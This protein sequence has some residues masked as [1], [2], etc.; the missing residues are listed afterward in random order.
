MNFSPNQEDSPLA[1]IVEDDRFMRM[2]LTTVMEQD[3]YQVVEASNGEE[4][5]TAYTRYQ[6]DVVLLDAIMPIMDGFT[7]CR[8]LQ[9]LPRGASTPILMITSLN[10]ET[11][12]DLAFDVGATDFITKPIHWA[13]LRQRVRRMLQASRATEKLQRNFLRERLITGISQH[14]RRSLNLKDI[15]DTTVVDV[16]QFLGCDQV[17]VYRFYPDGS[18]TVVSEQGILSNHKMLGQYI[19]DPCLPEPYP[20][21]FYQGWF[22]EIADLEQANLKPD[23]LQLL[24][25]LGIKARLVVPILKGEILW[26]LLIAHHYSSSREWFAEEIELLQQLADQLSLALAQAELLETIQ[27]REER[28]RQLA[29]NIDDVFWISDP[30]KNKIIYISPAYEKIWGFSCESIYRNAKSFLDAIPDEDRERVIA[31]LPKQ[32]LGNYDEE[33]RVVQPDGTIRWIRDRAFPISDATGQ[34]YRIVGIAADITQRKQAEANIYQALQQEKEFSELKSRFISIAS[35]EFRTPLT[36]ILAAAES[37]EYYGHK[38]TEEKKTSYLQRIKQSVKYMT[39]MLNDVL[40]LAKTEAGKTASNPTWIDLGEF[41]Y[42]LTQEIQISD[43]KQHIITF[44]SCANSNGD[45]PEKLPALTDEKSLR[46]IFSNL[47]SNAIKYSPL[48][49]VI[50]FK[51][52]VSDEVAVFQIQDQGIGVPVEDQQRLF[53]SF[54]RCTNVGNIPGTGL[55]LAIVKKSVDLLGGSITIDSEVGV[56]TTFTVMLPLNTYKNLPTEKSLLNEQ[57]ISS[58]KAETLRAL[59]GGMNTQG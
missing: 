38:W 46:H 2:Q 22:D 48:G 18:G 31:A 16:Q 20:Q 13:V 12:V 25:K 56:G 53:E 45:T 41:C 54:H 51:L 28:F 5:L 55:G 6:P 11:S 8:Q 50:R 44:I 52:M 15:L 10:D 29:E 36:T 23:H 59:S 27:E 4:A 3:G 34:V 42:D 7:C 9:K 26:G 17:L 47:L 24:Q 37:F 43:G 33:Y 58:N 35:H 57:S 39:T 19:S 32:R 49:S 14:I 1:L 21:L 30:E 40:V